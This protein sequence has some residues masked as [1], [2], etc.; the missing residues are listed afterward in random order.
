[1]HAASSE[2]DLV[3]AQI[4]TE[5]EKDRDARAI[6]EKKGGANFGGGAGK[7]SK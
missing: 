3:T 5:T 4:E 1:M 6:F 7:A 2:K